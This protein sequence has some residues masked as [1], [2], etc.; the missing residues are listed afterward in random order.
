MGKKLISAALA[1]LILLAG[2]KISRDPKHFVETSNLEANVMTIDQRESFPPVIEVVGVSYKISDEF[3]KENK[4]TIEPDKE[5]KVEKIIQARERPSENYL[6]KIIKVEKFDGDIKILKAP[7]YR[8]QSNHC[9]EYSQR[10]AK[11][12]YGKN[13]SRGNAWDLGKNNQIV[14]EIK[15][16]D[17]LIALADSGILKPGMIIGTYNP[18]SSVNRKGRKYTH[19]VTYIGKN[20]DNQPEFIHQ[21]GTIQEK[22]DLNELKQKKLRPVEIIDE[23]EISKSSD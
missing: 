2:A 12:I 13:Y 22:M 23:K 1:T 16:T 17:D 6:E 10:A 8:I 20:E 14:Q 5:I 9:S 18:G 11:E 7:R 21:W 4:I 19:V 15:E 3:G